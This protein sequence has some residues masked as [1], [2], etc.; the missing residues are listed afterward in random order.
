MAVMKQKNERENTFKKREKFTAKK[1]THKKEA[2]MFLIIIHTTTTTEKLFVDNF[3]RKKSTNFS[4][5]K[6]R[7][8][9]SDFRRPWPCVRPSRPGGRSIPTRCRTKKLA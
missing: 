7:F 3:P 2:G 9:F 6:P 1:R 4:T 5:K 8:I